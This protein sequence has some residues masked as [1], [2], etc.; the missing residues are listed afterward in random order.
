MSRI[1]VIGGAGNNLQPSYNSNY[2]YDPVQNQWG[3]AYPMPTARD[4][5]AAVMLD[6]LIYVIG[7]R[8]FS[9]NVGRYNIVEAYSPVS[10]LWY[11]RTPLN[12]GRGGPGADV[13]DGRIYVF[14]GEWFESSGSGI[15]PEVEVL[16]PFSGLWDTISVMPTP[17]HGMGTAS[18]G[19]TIYHIGGGT[20]AGFS[21]SD[22][23]EGFVPSKVI[24][25]TK[26][27]ESPVIYNLYQ[28]YPNPFNP[29]TNI[30][31]RIP[32]EIQGPG[33]VKLVIYDIFGREVTTLVNEK[34]NPGV[35]NVKWDALRFSSGV[36][37]YVLSAGKYRTSKKMMFLK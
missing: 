1:Y 8:D 32:D 13:M 5:I 24:G 33:I 18:A 6:S 34:L 31:F 7:G 12:I 15:V 30:E 37:F 17:R 36:Y 35:Y 21:Y 4:H 29:V 19:D 28:N 9:I 11:T 26:I 3:A 14:G 16:D 10:N 25:I 2:V 22:I 20:T 23:N 27:S